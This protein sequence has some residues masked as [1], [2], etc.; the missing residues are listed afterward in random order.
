MD[1]VPTTPTFLKDLSDRFN[2]GLY[3]PVLS[4]FLSDFNKRE[5]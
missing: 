1:F 4:V 5:I 2:C 3:V